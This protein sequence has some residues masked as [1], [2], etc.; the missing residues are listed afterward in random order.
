MKQDNKM[1]IIIT[2]LIITLNLNGVNSPIKRYRVAEW[3]KKKRLSM[4]PIYLR[5][6][7]QEGHTQTKCEE[8]GKYIACQCK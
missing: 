8:V 2:L 5:D 1:A 4:L 3:I 6:R 7:V